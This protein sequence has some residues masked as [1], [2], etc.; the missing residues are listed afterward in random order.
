MF[1]RKVNFCFV[2]SLIVRNSSLCYMIWIPGNRG[3]QL[4]ENSGKHLD[5]THTVKWAPKD[6]I[7]IWPKELIGPTSR[8]LQSA[9]QVEPILKTKVYQTDKSG[10]LC[11][12]DKE[13]SGKRPALTHQCSQLKSHLIKTA[14]IG[15]H[16][17]LLLEIYVMN[18]KS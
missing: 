6:Y 16:F 8:S 1:N 5:K 15:K 14:A 17:Q 18:S 3:H 4:N 9:N 2:L 13:T 11:S 7:F 10:R 12:E